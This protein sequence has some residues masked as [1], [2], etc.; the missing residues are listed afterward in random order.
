M[1]ATDYSLF[2]YVFAQR[3]TPSVLT[4]ELMRNFDVTAVALSNLSAAYFWSYAVVQNPVGLA[5]DRWGPRRVLAIAA[6]LGNVATMT[7]LLYING[8][9]H[10]TINAIL[11]LNGAF[12]AGMVVSF[13]LVRENK[14]N[15]DVGAAIA[16]VNVGVICSGALA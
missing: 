3:T 5:V 9:S 15:R 1:L 14:D 10:N 2:F 13:S 8:L 11:A 4:T 6:A 16:I 12:C 7:A